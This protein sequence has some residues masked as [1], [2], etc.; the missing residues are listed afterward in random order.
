[1][2]EE[3]KEIEKQNGIIDVVEKLLS[4]TNKINQDKN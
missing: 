2:G 4:L 3:E 1:M